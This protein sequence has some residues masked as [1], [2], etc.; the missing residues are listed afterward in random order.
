MLMVLLIKLDDPKAPVLFKQKRVGKNQIVFEMYKFRTMMV[1]SE[2]MLGEI[3]VLNEVKGAMFKIEKDPRITKIGKIL[4]K[5]SLDEFPQLLNVIKGDMS[6]IGPRPP[7]V[8]EV[9]QYSD[10]HKKRLEVRPGC[11]GL[12]QV[13][14]RNKLSFEE[15]VK[16]DLVYINSWS[17]WGDMK[18]FIKT[19]KVLFAQEGY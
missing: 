7:L 1:G 11:T 17:F 10:Y 16:L 8:S 15:M 13:S 2:D 3:L 4:R 14:G 18:I 19:F 9:E 6:L 12:W 5:T